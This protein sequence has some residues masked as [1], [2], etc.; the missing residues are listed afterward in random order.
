[1][2]VFV[3]TKQTVEGYRCRFPFVVGALVH[4][5]TNRIDAS[6]RGHLQNGL[7]N[8]SLRTSIGAGSKDVIGQ[9][10][11]KEGVETRFLADENK[12]GGLAI[13]VAIGIVL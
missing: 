9:L 8:L 4:P 3:V 10:E 5:C 11:A 12:A 2:L 13:V 7:G 1:M 6:D